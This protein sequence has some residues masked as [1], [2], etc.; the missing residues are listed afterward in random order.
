M[1]DTNGEIQSSFDPY[2]T[3]RE[4]TTTKV[5]ISDH[6]VS[7]CFCCLTNFCFFVNVALIFF[8]MKCYAHFRVNFLYSKVVFHKIKFL[9]NSRKFSASSFHG[10][11]ISY[12][13]VVCIHII[14]NTQD[15]TRI[16]SDR[17]VGR[18]YLQSFPFT[19]LGHYRLMMFY[20]WKDQGK[21]KT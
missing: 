13:N 11:L 2:R 3:F 10:T 15:A 12:N 21:V 9:L 7:L 14:R 1:K 8:I 4:S 18:E 6:T 19:A 5:S 17:K 16:K 20:T